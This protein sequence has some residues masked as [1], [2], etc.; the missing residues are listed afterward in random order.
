MPNRF[1]KL[2]NENKSLVLFIILMV[3][4]RSAVADYSL[5]PTGSMQPTIV[6]GDVIL[7]NKI[8]YDIR[9]PLSH[10]SLIKLGDPK[11]GDI[12]IFDSKVS[13]LRLVKRVIGVPGDVLEMYNNQLIINGKKLKYSTESELTNVSKIDITENLLGLEHSV[14]IMPYRT[15]QTSFRPIMVPQGYY[16]AMGDSRDNSADSRVIGLVPRHEIIGRT[17]RTLASVD[18]EKYLKPKFDRFLRDL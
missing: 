11:R 13:D 7:I 15:G 12:I 16:F 1:T 9:V 6:E 4:F 10:T 14:R 2:W 3:A 5:V 18:L 8:A 17:K